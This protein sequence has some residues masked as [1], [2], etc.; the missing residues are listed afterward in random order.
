MVLIFFLFL[1]Y[2]DYYLTQFLIIQF[3]YDPESK[4]QHS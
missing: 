3:V 4:T 1:F 2:L